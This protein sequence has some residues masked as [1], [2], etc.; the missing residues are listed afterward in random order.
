VNGGYQLSV[1]S[2][3]F[4]AFSLWRTVAGN[5]ESGKSEEQPKAGFF[6]DN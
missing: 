5:Q 6:T 4:S 1:V 3:Q 2:C